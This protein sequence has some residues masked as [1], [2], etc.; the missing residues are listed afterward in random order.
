LDIGKLFT[1]EDVK[2]SAF[3]TELL[4]AFLFMTIFCLAKPDFCTDLG[5]DIVMMQHAEN[6]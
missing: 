4:L 3:L 5:S 2:A 6:F 1:T